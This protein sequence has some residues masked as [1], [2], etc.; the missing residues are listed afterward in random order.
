MEILH[1]EVVDMSHSILSVVVASIFII[2]L[3]SFLYIVS[4]SA[5]L[6]I[7]MF[8][9][10]LGFIIFGYVNHLD[11]QYEYQKVKVSDWNI[12]HNE[13]WEVIKREGEIIELKR[14]LE[15]EE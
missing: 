12:V 10:S 2:I 13:G 3:L 5:L 6:S 4:G 11:E 7:L 9:I 8:I 14:K 1:Y 15:E